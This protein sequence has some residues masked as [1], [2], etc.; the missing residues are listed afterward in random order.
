MVRAS[1]SIAFAAPDPG[2]SRTIGRPDSPPSSTRG[3]SG[4]WPSSGSSSS[5]ARR[6]PPPDPKMGVGFLQC[7]HSNSH[8][9]DNPEHRHAHAHEHLAPAQGVARRDVLRR[10]SDSRRRRALH[11]SRRRAR[12]ADSISNAAS[13]RERRNALYLRDHVEALRNEP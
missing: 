2:S 10:R 12:C 5:S 13:Y 11:F 6:C 1:A 4:T 8:V 3:Y 7:G 9:L